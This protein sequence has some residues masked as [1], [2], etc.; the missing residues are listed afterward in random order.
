MK[1]VSILI[2][3]IFGVNIGLFAQKSTRYY[4][5]EGMQVMIQYTGSLDQV[6]LIQISGKRPGIE[7]LAWLKA[8][9]NNT[10]TTNDD[11]KK[12]KEFEVTD[13]SGQKYRVRLYENLVTA[14]LSKFNP[15]GKV[16]RIWD[17]KGRNGTNTASGKTLVFD[18]NYAVKFDYDKKTKK[19]TNL[20]F[21]VDKARQS[22]SK[23]E[24]YD[25]EDYEDGGYEGKLYTVKDG[26]GKKFTI[27]YS[28]SFDYI[29]VNTVGNRTESQ[30]TLHL[31]R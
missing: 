18:G 1:Q 27:L 15:D 23:F 13:E 20:Q 10:K 26:E 7:K 28:D 21:S 16:V 4:D 31:K 17:L 6:S 29:Q 3:L 30:T 2:L 25:V 9:V 14:T 12:V 5:G 11:G 22:Y 8:T 24:V 19:M